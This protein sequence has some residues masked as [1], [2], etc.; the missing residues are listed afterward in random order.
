MNKNKKLIYAAATIFIIGIIFA[1]FTTQKYDTSESPLIDYTDQD[2]N[3]HR[4]PLLI[5]VLPLF[6][7]CIGIGMIILLK[8]CSP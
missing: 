7:A 3:L 6:W 1:G 2:S 8:I 5:Q 4:F